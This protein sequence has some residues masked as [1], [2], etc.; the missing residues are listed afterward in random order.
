MGMS[1]TFYA[2][3]EYD[4]YIS[5]YIAFAQKNAEIIN[6][7]TPKSTLAAANIHFGLSSDIL[8]SYHNQLFTHFNESSNCFV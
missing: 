5:N 6:E 1:K 4:L 8:S 2:F 7:P 3:G